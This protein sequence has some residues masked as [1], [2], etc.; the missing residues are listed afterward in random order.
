MVVLYWENQY[1]RK[2]VTQLKM[3]YKFHPTCQVQ[4]ITCDNLEGFAEKDF[5]A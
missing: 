5:K 4:T 2:R 3:V 1:T